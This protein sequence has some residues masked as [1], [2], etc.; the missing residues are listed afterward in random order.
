[1]KV[2]FKCYPGQAVRNQPP[3]FMANLDEAE[4]L[5]AAGIGEIVKAEEPKPDAV[6]PEII[7]IKE[8]EKPKN[9]KEKKANA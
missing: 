8:P 4:A 9:K 6:E 3:E 1:M 5:Q 7:E 2:T